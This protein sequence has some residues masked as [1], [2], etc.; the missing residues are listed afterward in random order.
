MTFIALMLL[1]LSI[2]V[3][4]KHHVISFYFSQ[5]AAGSNEKEMKSRSLNVSFEISLSVPFLNKSMQ[6]KKYFFFSKKRLL[7]T[8]CGIA[9]CHLPY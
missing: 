5:F 4:E 7:N 8:V 3:L 2:S 9:M 6:S 1:I